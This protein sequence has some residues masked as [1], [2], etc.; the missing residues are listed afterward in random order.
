MKWKRGTRS[1][2]VIDIRGASGGSSAGGRSSLPIPAGL[3][4][5]GGGVGLLVVLVIVGIN[6]FSGGGGGDGGFGLPCAFGPGAG[7]PGVGDGEGIPPGEDP[8]ADLKDFSS[9]VFTDTQDVWEG[10]LAEDGSRYE[11]AELFLY[12]D[13][14]STAA[15]ATRPQRSVPSTAPPTSAS[16]STSPS[17]TT[18]AASSAPPA[19]SP[20]PT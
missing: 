18:C 5:A 19:T 17:T 11:R 9:Y 6:M 7:P 13:A 16:I 14:V 2:D 3:A 10:I 15:A 4:G 8:Q 20:G 12:S 1:R